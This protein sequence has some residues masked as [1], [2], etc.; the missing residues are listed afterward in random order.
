LEAWRQ[1]AVPGVCRAR[2]R[3]RETSINLQAVL[4]LAHNAVKTFHGQ[5]GQRN[6]E[7]ARLKAKQAEE[8]LQAAGQ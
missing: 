4:E 6:I 7:A 5:T 3:Y 1:K 8:R 2:E